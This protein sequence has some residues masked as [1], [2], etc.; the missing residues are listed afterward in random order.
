MGVVR[1][2]RVRNFR[3]IASLDWAPNEGINAIIGPGDVGKSTILEALDLVIGSRRSSF[4]DTDFHCTDVTKPILIE[5]TVGA[6]PKPLTDLEIYGAALRGWSASDGIA[7][8][9]GEGFEPVLT[10][11]LT[12]GDDGEPTRCLYSERIADLPRDMRSDHRAL[13]AAQRLGATVG[14][15]LAWGPRSVLSQLS[16]GQAGISA[17]LARASRAAR[18]DFDIDDA[19]DLKAAV[20]VAQQVAKELAVPRAYDASAALDPRSV[21]VSN[22][23]I[24]L[25]DANQVPLRCLGTGSSRLMAAGLQARAAELVPVLLLDEAEHGLE[26]HRITRLL[27]YLGS[28]SKGPQ[29]FLTTHSPIV[30]RELSADQLYIARRTEK[31]ELC[32]NRF[33][34]TEQGLIRTHPDAFLSAAV[35][36]CEGATEKGLMRGLDLFWSD[37]GEYSFGFLGIS[38]VDG[39]GTPKAQQAAVSFLEAGFQV[40]LLRDSDKTSPENEQKLTDRG[41]PIFCWRDGYATENELFDSLPLRALPLLLQLADQHHTPQVVDSNLAGH[42]L[43]KAAIEELR[44]VPADIHR[45]VLA[46]A[47]RSGSWFK[48]MDFGEEVGRTIV[49]P[50]YSELTGALQTT[51]MEVWH[52]T[53]KFGPT[54]D[55]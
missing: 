46:K 21:N 33:S 18:Q 6:L 30:L 7:D 23:A 17:V 39:G 12:V 20:D 32:P 24:A 48:R 14:Q 42:A 49:G 1:F 9:P 52:W 35:L 2:L 26:P 54:S 51:I 13:I 53:R 8:E 55:S 27:H 47:A 4:T 11:R 10:L 34:S 40:A 31:Q 3:G 41:A 5:V 38:L 15:H 29:V 28:K 50:F 43:S 22:G 44:R 19:P 16:T 37:E 25:H 36:V 45:E